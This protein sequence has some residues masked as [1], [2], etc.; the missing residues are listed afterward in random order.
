MTDYPKAT[1]DTVDLVWVYEFKV[2][3]PENV[4]KN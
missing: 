2:L 3:E 1:Q 4:N